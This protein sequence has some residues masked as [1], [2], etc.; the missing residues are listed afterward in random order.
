MRRSSR[1]EKAHLRSPVRDSGCLQPRQ[2][3]GERSERERPG[4]DHGGGAEP[5]QGAAAGPRADQGAG[6]AAGAPAAERAD[7]AE[8]TGADA[9]GLRRDSSE[10]AART[11]LCFNGR[12]LAQ[13]VPKVYPV[14]MAGFLAVMAWN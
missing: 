2:G 10:V 3:A 7:G 8:A 9:E 1:Y 11:H 12:V 5:E 4:A 14:L 13:R 6:H